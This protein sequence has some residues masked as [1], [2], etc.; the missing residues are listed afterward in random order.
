MEESLVNHVKQ[1]S[2][3]SW[4][5]YSRMAR[6]VL[7]NNCCKRTFCKLLV[8]DFD[9]SEILIN[10]HKQQRDKIQFV[11]FLVSRVGIMTIAGLATFDSLQLGLHWG[12][13]GAP[14]GVLWGSNRGPLGVHVNEAIACSPND[15]SK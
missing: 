3:S 4:L 6:R 5:P 11:Y 7:R 14:S 1:H 15:L 9:K 10:F 12:S 8:G 13:I 2:D